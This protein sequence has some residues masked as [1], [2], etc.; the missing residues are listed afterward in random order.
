MKSFMELKV[1][2]PEDLRKNENWLFNR[3]LFL[4]RMESDDP[5]RFIG[6]L[7][8][9]ENIGLRTKYPQIWTQAFSVHFEDYKRK[10]SPYRPLTEEE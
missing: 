7:F 4:I 10:Y 2:N 5:I 1:L 8:E 9:K 6:D 3:I